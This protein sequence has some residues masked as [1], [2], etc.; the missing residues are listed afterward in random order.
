MSF[1][2]GE[3]IYQVY[4]N[5]DSIDHTTESGVDVK[6]KGQLLTSILCTEETSQGNF[7]DEEF[8]W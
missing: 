7:N 8:A 3:Y 4:V 5:L 2:K 6:H 1:Q